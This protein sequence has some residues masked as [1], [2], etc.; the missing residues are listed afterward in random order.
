MNIEDLKD[1]KT[2][3]QQFALELWQRTFAQGLKHQAAYDAAEELMQRI[4]PHCTSPAALSRLAVEWVNDPV[5]IDAYLQIENGAAQEEFMPTRSQVV[6]LLADTLD[7]INAVVQRAR[8]AAAKHK[9]RELRSLFL[10]NR[11]L[12]MQVLQR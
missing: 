8:G 9:A 1:C 11:E 2:L 12:L 4:Y 10:A 6:L 5:V 7:G 3:K